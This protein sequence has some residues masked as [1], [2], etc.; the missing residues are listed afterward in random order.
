MLRQNLQKCVRLLQNSAWC[1]RFR[2]GAAKPAP[3]SD[4][5]SLGSRHA[6]PIF[7]PKVPL[8]FDELGQMLIYKHT[9][10]VG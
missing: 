8:V 2:S 3:A 9:R 10:S 5:P 4:R 7:K 1:A 6:L